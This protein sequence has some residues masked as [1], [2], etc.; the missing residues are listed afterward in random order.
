MKNQHERLSDHHLDGSSHGG[1]SEMAGAVKFAFARLVDWLSH[2]QIRISPTTGRLLS[3][4][5]GDRILL[6]SQLFCV[7]KIYVSQENDSVVYSLGSED[8]RATLK[9]QRD[10]NG[11]A[12]D[13]WLEMVG[14]S[15]PVFDDDVA[16][17]SRTT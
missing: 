9:I 4:Q 10:Q 1:W 17:L 15:E 8:K 3:L 5:L 13:G 2:D 14:L 7:L 11:K 6:R 16:V 12:T